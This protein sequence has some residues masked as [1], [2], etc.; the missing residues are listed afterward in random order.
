[1]EGETG[2]HE[3]VEK[4]CRS[5]GQTKNNCKHMKQN[6]FHSS[7]LWSPNSYETNESESSN[8][9]EIIPYL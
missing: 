8:G 6:W 5:S 7:Y 4:H 9:S 3:W 1:M 2:R